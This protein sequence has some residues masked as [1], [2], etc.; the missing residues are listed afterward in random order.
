MEFL[1]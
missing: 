1:K